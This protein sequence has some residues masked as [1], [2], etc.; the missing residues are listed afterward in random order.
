MNRMKKNILFGGMLLMAAAFTGCTED[1]KDWAQPISNPEPAAITIPGVSASAAASS[2]NLGEA[3]DAVKLISVSTAAAPEGTVFDKLRVVMTPAGIDDAESKT[4]QALSTSEGTFDKET[5]QEMVVETFGRR[6]EAR[7]YN[8]HVYLDGIYQGQ[9]AYIDAGALQLNLIPEAPQIA[10]NYYI[11]G[12][13]QDWAESAKNKSQQFQH[14]DKD[15]YEDPIFTIVID[16]AEGDTWFAIG[17]DA[18]CE[19]IA[20]DNDWSKLLGTTAGNGMNDLTGTLDFRY[21]LSDDGSL[22]VPAGYKRLKITLNMMDY[23]FKIEGLNIADDYYLI[24]GPGEWNAESAMSMPLHHSDKSVFDDPVFTYT[25]EG[26]KEM[27][28]AF[29]DKEAIDAVASGTWNQLYGTTGASEDLTGSFDRRYNLDGDHS[30]HVDGSAKMYRFTINMAELT[31]EIKELNFNEYIY[32]AGVNNDWGAVEQP[33][34]CANQD[35]I[36]TGFF[37]AQD[38]DWSGGKGAFKFTGAF[39]NWDNG[40]YGTGTMSDDGLTGTLIDDGGSGNILVEPGFYRADVNLAAMTYTLTPIAGIGIIG[41][42]QAGGWD[43]DTDLTYNPATRAWEA[44][45]ELAA[46][47]FKFRAN[48]DWA[49]NWGGTADNLTQDGPNLKVSEAGTYFIQFFPLCAT[50]A[51]CTM[52]KQ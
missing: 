43:S 46:D 14:S 32:E 2:I 21:N 49:I 19:A 28:F 6:P 5:L 50:K 16:A 22:M 44:T 9:A 51:Y 31:Y 7:T 25:F 42:A 30:F 33:L 39:N 48:D 8:T 15:V 35:G 10:Q 34:Y 26:G 17:D 45:I 40:N 37:Y 41:P 1:F 18:A 12:G 38:A 29:G 27:W 20:N 52:T 4:I 24:G 13:T 23:T 36:Y 3:S 11:V 47:E